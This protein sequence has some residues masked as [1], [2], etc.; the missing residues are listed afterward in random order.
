MDVD[1]EEKRLWVPRQGEDH[2]LESSEFSSVGE[3]Q[4][5]N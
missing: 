5:D 3:T 2:S 1:G 4:G